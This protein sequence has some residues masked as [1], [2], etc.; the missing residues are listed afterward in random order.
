MFAIL[1]VFMS[2]AKFE[3]VSKQQF[4]RDLEDL[5]GIQNDCYEQIS[6]PKRATKGSAGYDFCCSI[7]LTIHAHESI[8]IPTGIRCKMAEGYVLQ[9]YPRS[10]LGFKYHL[11]LLNTVGIIDSDYYHADNEGHII[12]G[13]INESDKDLVLKAGDRFIQGVFLKYETAEEE[14]TSAER[15][16]GFGS[17]N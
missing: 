14:E 4:A 9:L 1:N 10:S 5:L 3:K 8:R 7:D 12:A 15:H 11:C 16:G 17:T 13:M 6:L 2:I